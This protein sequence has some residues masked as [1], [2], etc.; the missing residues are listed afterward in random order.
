M[1]KLPQIGPLLVPTL[2]DILLASLVRLFSGGLQL[3]LLVLL[4]LGPILLLSPKRITDVGPR[5]PSSFAKRLS[6]ESPPSVVP[7]E[8][9]DADEKRNLES[10]AAPTGGRVPN[11]T[12]AARGGSGDE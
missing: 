4:I 12:E 5:E 3:A 10:R 6:V 2:A 11:S 9:A 7:T 8:P 1:R